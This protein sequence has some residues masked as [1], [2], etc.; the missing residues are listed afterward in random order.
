MLLRVRFSSDVSN[1][2]SLSFIS[3]QPVDSSN[4]KVTKLVPFNGQFPWKSKT[5]KLL[6]FR[7]TR[8]QRLRRECIK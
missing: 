6:M 7:K 2:G 3:Q 4:K 5:R 1:I 8:T